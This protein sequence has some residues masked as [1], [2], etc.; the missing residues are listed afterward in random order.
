MRSLLA[1]TLVLILIAIHETGQAI[2]GLTSGIPAA[3][4]VLRISSRVNRR[5]GPIRCRPSKMP[6]SRLSPPGCS[7]PRPLVE[8]SGCQAQPL[9]DGSPQP[10]SKTQPYHPNR[11]PHCALRSA[12]TDARKEA[13]RWVVDHTEAR[14]EAGV[15]LAGG[16]KSRGWTEKRG[17]TGVS[18]RVRRFFFRY[19]R[20]PS[21][22]RLD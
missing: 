6:G 12:D 1:L 2:A 5:T 14:S 10:L 21:M 18:S 13:R 16:L 4:R 8:L 3:V 22:N 19:Y 11:L 15:G 20:T 9:A 7:P 17:E